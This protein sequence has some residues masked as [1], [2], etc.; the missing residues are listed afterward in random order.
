M[1]RSP[2]V[3]HLRQGSQLDA[4]EFHGNRGKR[5]EEDGLPFVV[6]VSLQEGTDGFSSSS[7]EA[8]EERCD[9]VALGPVELVADLLEHLP[10]QGFLLESLAGGRNHRTLGCFLVEGVNPDT[11]YVPSHHIENHHVGGC[12]FE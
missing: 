1:L 9:V 3:V 4:R 2:C 7:E 11:L 6:A 10:C 8:A 12:R 5:P